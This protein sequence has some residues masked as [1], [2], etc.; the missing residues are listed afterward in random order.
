MKRSIRIL[1]CIL[2]VAAVFGASASAIVPYASFTYSNTGATLESPHAYVPDRIIDSNYLDLIKPLDDPKDLFIDANNNVYI[3]DTKNNRIVICDS[4]FK[5]F[6]FL[7][8]F[9]NG[10]GV[11]DSLLSPSGVFVT[12]DCIYVADTDNYRIVVFNIDGSFNRIVE[13]P[14]ADVF[15]EGH[16]YKPVALAVDRA[17]RLYV[18]SS[19]THYGI[20]QL[21]PDGKFIMFL[22]AQKSS[23][24]LW[25]IFWRQF[26][27]AEQNARSEKVVPTEYNNI[28]ID[29]SGFVYAT[30]NSLDKG[31]MRSAIL[32]KSKAGTYAPVKKLNAEGTDVMARN[33]F[34]PPSGEVPVG[35]ANMN[36]G[37]AGS[38]SSIIDVALGPQNTMTLFD[39][40]R[41]RFYTYDEQGNLL[42][43]FGDKGTQIGQLQNC[44][45]ITY[46]GTDLLALD[47]TTDAI[48]I[49][50]RTDY[51]DYIAAALQNQIDRTYD[52][53]SEYWQALLQRNSNFDQAYIG[54]G[55][56]LYRS[57][58]YREAMEYYEASSDTAAYSDCFKKIRQEW[59][60]KYIL[61]IPAVII[62]VC[63]VVSRFLK[64]AAK[65]NKAG[66]VTK[67]KRTLKEAFLYGFHVIFHPFDGFWDLKHEKRGNL[68]GAI[69]ILA[70]TI[71]GY[72]YYG[73]GRSYIYAPGN[74]GISFIGEIFSILT[75]YFL[76]CVA[77][78]CLTTLFDGEGSFKDIC[79]ATAYAILPLP[80]IMIP[81]T[82]L[83]NVITL[84]EVQIINLLIQVAYIWAGFLLFFGMMVTHDYSLSKN[85][86]TTLGTLVGMAFIMFIGVLFSGLVAKLFTF[87]YNIYVEL[88][89]RV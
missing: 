24:S 69:L 47:T 74:N 23:L 33:G 34:F 15:P 3:A 2:C 65:V 79:I 75:P 80:I 83:T 10:E 89:Y 44:S 50:K 71:A 39:S 11:P 40:E 36:G 22:G 9:T 88:S 78:W 77:N 16:I 51:G 8:T 43:I 45:S 7:D 35:V 67:D 1:I 63:I 13:E 53:A 29:S 87:F 30:T 61:I 85:I 26:R 49:Y 19:T 82:L 38:V 20:I 28:T 62:V 76:W 70:I 81:T 14:K 32:G 17:G 46:M 57:Y 5:P 37:T 84:Q 56:A 48:T 41:Q 58:K 27:T 4:S 66:Q 12:N 64:Y 73:I 42:Y 86:L 55:D 68:K 21:Y 54:I 6:M 25:Q 31:A 60:E 72:I 59:I 52:K 18:V